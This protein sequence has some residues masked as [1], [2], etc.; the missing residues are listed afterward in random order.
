[1]NFWSYVCAPKS[2]ACPAE[3]TSGSVRAAVCTRGP[4]VDCFDRALHRPRAGSVQAFLAGL[5]GLGHRH[6]RTCPSRAAKK[7]RAHATLGLVTSNRRQTEPNP[8][9]SP[10]IRHIVTTRRRCHSFQECLRCQN[11]PGARS[12]AVVSHTRRPPTWTMPLATQNKITRSSALSLV[13]SFSMTY[14]RRQLLANA[15]IAASRVA[16]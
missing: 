7:A 11:S 12:L 16:A 4:S 5:R 8:S 1:M 13:V 15:A 6:V 9:E 14:S 2:A 3:P 10:P